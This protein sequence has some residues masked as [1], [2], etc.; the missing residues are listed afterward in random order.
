V[1]N[2]VIAVASALCTPGPYFPPSM[3]SLLSLGGSLRAHLARALMLAA[4]RCCETSLEF[5]PQFDAQFPL[6]EAVVGAVSL[7]LPLSPPAVADAGWTAMLVSHLFNLVT[8]VP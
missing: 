2:P 1:G 7:A 5:V 3:L 4:Q 6:P 8:Q